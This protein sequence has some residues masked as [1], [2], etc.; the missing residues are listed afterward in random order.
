M[1]KIEQ[2]EIHVHKRTLKAGLP[3]HTLAHEC[4]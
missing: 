1:A 2:K 3:C 4:K